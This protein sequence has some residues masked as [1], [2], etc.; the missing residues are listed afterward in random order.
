VASIRKRRIGGAFV[1]RSRRCEARISANWRVT[2]DRRVCL[3]PSC[4]GYASSPRR[5]MHAMSRI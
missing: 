4:R 3:R 2:A 1:M 5:R